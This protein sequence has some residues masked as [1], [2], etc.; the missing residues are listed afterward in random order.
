MAN[1]GV[2]FDSKVVF[3][4]K[5]NIGTEVPTHCALYGSDFY[6]AQPS[7]KGIVVSPVSG[8]AV[9]RTGREEH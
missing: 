2:Y 8:G 9:G 4:S 3:D 7:D 1:T 5:G 6:F